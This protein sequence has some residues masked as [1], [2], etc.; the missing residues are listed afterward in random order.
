MEL[1][2]ISRAT[3]RKLK[4]PAASA[5]AEVVAV[6]EGGPASAAGIRTG[7]IVEEI[8]STPSATACEL[9]DAP[10]N[11]PDGPARV[12]L[13]G[14]AGAPVEK[15]VVS[16]EQR[17]LLEKSCR[18][19]ASAACYRLA[20]TLF[21]GDHEDR[22]R[23]GELED[24]A[25]RSGFAEACSDQGLRLALSGGDGA[26]APL[27]RACDLGSGSGCEHLGLLYATGKGV[28]RDDGRATKEYVRS[29]ELG[30]ARGCYN[31][32]LMSDD[33]RGTPRDH[34]RAAAYY[35]EACALGSSTA[36]TNLGFLYENGRGVAKDLKLSTALYQRGC[37]GT[38][39]QPSNLTG[40]VNV[41]RAYR[42]GLGVAVDEPRA[43]ALFRE[44]CDRTPDADDVGSAENR[45]RACS[46]LGALYLAGDG[47]PKDNEG[48][49]AFSELG[50]EQGDAFGCFNAASVYSSGAGVE[51]NPAKAAEF[52]DRAC[53]L[54]DAEGCYDLGIAYEKGNGVEADRSRAAE[55]FRK[56]CATGFKAACAR[57][58][59]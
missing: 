5:R 59:S 35:E 1:R 29:C 44:A 34:S 26:A 58:K 28:A 43:A 8:G 22:P 6:I 30:D 50:C 45:S 12:L 47:V 15:T 20:L 24:S 19:G 27:S 9:V 52:L 7:D 13:R 14:S 31:A 39:C 4:L 36:C 48:G 57:R 40:C 38:R 42:D 55:L 3:R 11:R 16:A 53:E 46:L 49:R 18:A 56:A 37:D 2:P 51:V 23:A 25:C 17:P 41:G 33:G 54:G 21:G 32:G 10:W